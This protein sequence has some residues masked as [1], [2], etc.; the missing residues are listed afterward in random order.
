MRLKVVILFLVFSLKAFS[1]SEKIEH[2]RAGITKLTGEE[3]VD[4]LNAIAY[5]F[6]M[7]HIH[8]DSSLQYAVRAYEEADK[9]GYI[10]GMVRSLVLQSEVEGRILD[11]LDRMEAK[12][13]EAIELMKHEPVT[14]DLIRAYG[15]L[16][17]A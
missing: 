8:S 14:G 3:K 16:G 6:I 2:L 11:K 4:V 12:S 15:C 17:L 1:Q 7:S 10:K 13:L 5:E 9:T